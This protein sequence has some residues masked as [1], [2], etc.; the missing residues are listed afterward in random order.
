MVKAEFNRVEAFFFYYDYDFFVSP[1]YPFSCWLFFKC[2]GEIWTLNSL[3]VSVEKFSICEDA[4]KK[5]KW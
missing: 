4:I 5:K 3:K 1:L 2:V